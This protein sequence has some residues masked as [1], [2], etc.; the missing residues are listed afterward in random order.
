MKSKEII[1]KL[2]LKADV[3]INGNRPWDIQVHN[4]AM[5]NRILK[6]PSLG[7]GESYMDKWWDCEELDTFFYKV[8]R[9]D[10]D[11]ELKGDFKLAFWTIWQSLV[12][13]QTK[14]KATEVGKVHYDIGNKLFE[15]MLDKRM[16]YTC[17]YWK[18]A[19]NLDE[20]Q[21]AKLDLICKKVGLK[22]GMKVLD[23]G[24]GW[25]GFLKYAAEKYGIKGVGIT[26]SKEQ[27]EL[28]K[29]NVK[30]LDVDI[31]FQDYRDVNEKFDAIVSIGMFEH[32]GP[33]NYRT[34]MK[35]VEKNLN[36]DGLFLLHT[37][38]DHITKRKP[39]DAW[40]NKYI[41]PNGTIPS[42]T[43]I[44]KAA[45]GIFVMEDWHNFSYYY[46]RTCK[47]WHNN[48]KNNW[49]E[50]KNDYDER[51]YRMWSYYLLSCVGN[52]KARGAQLWQIVFSKKGVEGGY[53]SIR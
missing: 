40:L 5:Y 33:K 15:K 42:Q 41:F 24:C 18:N 39:V 9:A 32:V 10:L 6:N 44:S 37:I 26:I 12:N 1:E 13:Q 43:R 31:R 17:G 21:E 36:D 48:F 35:V 14:K 16:I 46:S 34:F 47:E 27:V 49:D 3:I 52:F 45:D 23:I 2:F 19:E 30:G 25:G 4:E 11:E 22:P 20:A 38:G 8:L 53:D 50:L 7:L 29:E 51:F 28:G